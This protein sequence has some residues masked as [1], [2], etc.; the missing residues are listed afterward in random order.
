MNVRRD[1]GTRIALAY[2]RQ[3][4]VVDSRYLDAVRRA[5]GVPVPLWADDRKWRA[6]MADA[7]GLVLTGGG[8]IDP[9]LYGRHDLAATGL[10]VDK[11]RDEREMAA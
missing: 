9:L 3:H 10:E 11:A 2:V 1:E 8:D 5:G 4:S 6:K 7:A